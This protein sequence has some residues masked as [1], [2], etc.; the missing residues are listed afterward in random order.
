MQPCHLRLRAGP[1][2]VEESDLPPGEAA[3][4]PVRAGRAG[5]EAV[6]RRHLVHLVNA[7]V[8]GDPAA[9]LLAACNSVQ[10]ENHINIGQGNHKLTIKR[11]QV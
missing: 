3:V 10:T 2:E 7:A 1:G 11:M 9:R 4:E 5:A 6:G 8:G